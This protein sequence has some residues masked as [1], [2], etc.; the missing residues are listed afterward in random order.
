MRL[1]RERREDEAEEAEFNAK[2]AARPAKTEVWA[3]TYRGISKD[4][5]RSALFQVANKTTPRVNYDDERPVATLTNVRI[6]YSGPEL[7]QDDHEVFM[8]LVHMT[9]GVEFGAEV[10]IT[11]HAALEGLR[12][13]N[14]GESYERL[15]QC[16]WRLLKGT[17]I[18]QRKRELKHGDKWRSVYG[19]HLINS[20]H[21]QDETNPE[22]PWRIYLNTRMAT[23]LTGNDL[24]LID[25]MV[26]MKLNPLAQ[27]LHAFYATHS[28][29]IYPYKVAKL[30]ELCASRQKSLPAFRQQLKT[31]LDSLK[32]EGFIQTWSLDE[33]DLIR[34]QK[35]PPG[36]ASLL[37]E[38]DH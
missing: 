31:A 3:K 36:Q 34:V 6:T 1:D 29:P 17:V 21:A 10:E 16:F 19:E 25:Y 27:W 13:E 9:R 22:L 7:R 32:K 12:W 11:G 2:E 20:V 14:N 30:R 15:R 38:S 8:Q 35:N 4:L 5:T 28:A 18:V 37:L 26:R 33:G 24:T 23:L